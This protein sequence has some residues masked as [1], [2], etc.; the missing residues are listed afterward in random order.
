MGQAESGQLGREPSSPTD[1]NNLGVGV[2]NVLMKLGCVS[3]QDAC[4]GP[5]EEVLESPL[6]P[7]HPL[8][9]VPATFSE[10]NDVAFHHDAQV[11]Q[12][13][14]SEAIFLREFKTMMTS[15]FKLIQHDAGQ[16]TTRTLRLAVEQDR[17]IWGDGA[18]ECLPLADV[19]RVRRGAAGAVPEDVDERSL[20]LG[21]QLLRKWGADAAP[22]RIRRC[23][24]AT[25]GRRTES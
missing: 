14:K 13:N 25:M 20:C 2:V 18:T 9:G 7:P 16:A 23:C 4:D 12:M 22:Q 19:T 3:G 5:E 11:S 24:R 1:K 10:A 6:D 15:G 21:G 17:V 8:D